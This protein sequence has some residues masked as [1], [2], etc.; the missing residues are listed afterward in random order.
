M[1]LAASVGTDVPV[2]TTLS[3]DLMGT[4]GKKEVLSSTPVLVATK[5]VTETPPVVNVMA[6]VQEAE[7]VT[8]PFVQP[9]TAAVAPT[10]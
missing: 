9:S 1:T 8:L 7:Y 2:P 4:V 5:P 10:N 3:A 6:K